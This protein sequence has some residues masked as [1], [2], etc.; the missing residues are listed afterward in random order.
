MTPTP[1]K[2]KSGHHCHQNSGFSPHISLLIVP[3]KLYAPRRILNASGDVVPCFHLP[4]FIRRQHL[5]YYALLLPVSPHYIDRKE[6][7]QRHSEESHC[8]FLT[9]LNL[10]YPY[11]FLNRMIQDPITSQLLFLCS[12]T[13]LQSFNHALFSFYTTCAIRL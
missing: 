8:L 7:R 13:K 3:S 10:N 11:F 12:D 2:Q 6:K 4:A 5:H 1:S 9:I